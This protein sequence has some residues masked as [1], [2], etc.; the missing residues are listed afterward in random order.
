MKKMIRVKIISDDKLFN[1]VYLNNIIGI[2][3]W[4]VRFNIFFNR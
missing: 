3:L 1:G 2:N 4:E